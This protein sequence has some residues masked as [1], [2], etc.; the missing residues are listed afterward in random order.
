MITLRTV[1]VGWLSVIASGTNVS[2]Q[3]NDRPEEVRLRNDCRLAAQVLQTGH[4]AP[5]TAWAMEMIASCAIDGPP[6]L[7]YLWSQPSLDS[8][9]AERVLDA[10]SR[11]R[12]QRIA[13]AALHAAQTTSNP[14][15]V[16]LAGVILLVRYIDPHAGLAVPLLVPPTGW[17][18]GMHVRSIPLGSSP[19]AIPQLTGDAPLPSDF[20]DKALA[21]LGVLGA[22]DPNPRVQWAATGLVRRF[23]TRRRG[24]SAFGQP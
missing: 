17:R 2:G 5:K 11:L 24:G 23:E 1:L 16:R 10:S 18:P 4:P 13:G 9:R 21:A 20:A 6:I 22:G 15:A 3:G 7:A 8:A 19:H 12:D 14:E